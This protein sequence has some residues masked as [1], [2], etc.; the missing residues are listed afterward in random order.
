MLRGS[1]SISRTNAVEWVVAGAC[2]D[3]GGEERSRESV[4]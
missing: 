2:L 4:Y 3:A 1:G